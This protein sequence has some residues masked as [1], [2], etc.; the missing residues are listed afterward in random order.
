LIRGGVYRLLRGRSSRFVAVLAGIAL[1]AML[2]ASHVNAA[3]PVY[4]AAC[5]TP[6]DPITDTQAQCAALSER[7]EVL[8]TH[9]DTSTTAMIDARSLLGY[10]V[11]LICAL[12]FA[13][14]FLRT[15]ARNV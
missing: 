15:F 9:M 7:L 8:E 11:G 6:S 1:G 5:P 10:V 3:T 12:L 13:S 4:S 14:I 2:L